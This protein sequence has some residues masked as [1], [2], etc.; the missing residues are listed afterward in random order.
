MPE[1]TPESL[2]EGSTILLLKKVETWIPKNYRMITCLPTTFKNL[3][4][5]IKD[6]LYNYFGKNIKAVEQRDVKNDYHGCKHQLMIN[7]AILKNCRKR[8]KNLSTAWIDYKKVFDSVPHSWIIKYMALYKVHVM[9]T[10]FIKS[11]L[12]RWK[13]NITLVHKQEVLRNRT[14]QHKS[15]NIPGR[16]PIPTTLHN[17]TQSSQ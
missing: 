13:I 15:K 4:S 12:T 1:H 3:T 11:N 5:I 9:I 2:I 6:R 17:I 10:S 8:K 7:N 14:N 16:F